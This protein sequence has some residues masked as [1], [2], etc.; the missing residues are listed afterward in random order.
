MTFALIALALAG[1]TSACNALPGATP[2]PSVPPTPTPVPTPTP[3]PTFGADQISHP[4]GATD[5][6]LRM[7]QGG[8][9][10]PFGF[11]FTQS[12]AFTLYGDGTVIF[13]PLDNRGGNPFGSQAMLP[14][15]VGHMTEADIQTLLQFAL[16][17]GRLANARENYDNPNVA[18]AGS[19]FFNINAGGI[20]K[21][22]QIYALGLDDGPDAADRQGFTQLANVLNDFQSQSG[23][24]LGDLTAYEPALYKVLLMEG[25][26]EPQGQVLDWP[27]DDLTV[28]HWP[29][30]P[31][32]P[33]SR[34][35]F[36]DAAHV[37]KMTDVPNGGHVGVWVKTPDGKNVQLGIRPLLPDEVEA[38]NTAS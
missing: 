10:V 19:T 34:I 30:N 20:D 13:K 21:S 31:D 32:E 11:L 23:L 22:I 14:W 4:T 28:A 33:D 27:W 17:T 16:Q 9:F 38:H 25:F 12:P 2:T 15:L 6:V 8:G 1:L 35:A 7:E 5:I 37:A 3:S 36:L 29:A 26:G 24:D 18:D